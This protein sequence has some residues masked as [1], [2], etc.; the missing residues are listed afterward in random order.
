M[1]F[2]KCSYFTPWNWLYWLND[3]ER[4]RKSGSEVARIFEFNTTKDEEAEKKNAMKHKRKH[5]LNFNENCDIAENGIEMFRFFCGECQLANDF[6]AF[7]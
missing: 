6:H 5:A 4:V 3:T 2:N 1:R 7:H